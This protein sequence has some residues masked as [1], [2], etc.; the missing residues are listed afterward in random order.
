VALAC[1]EYARAV[2]V[3]LLRSAVALALA[4]G[5]VAAVVQP[6][7]ADQDV[8][9]SPTPD[10]KHP[11]ILDGRVYGIASRGPKVLV[12]GTFTTIRNGAFGTRQIRQPRLFRFDSDTGLIDKT[13]RPRINGDVE[14]VTYADGGTSILV[15]GSFTRVNGKVANRIAKLHL[16]GTL[17]RSFKASAARRVKDFALT[18]GRLILGGEFNKINGRDVQRLAAINPRTGAL[19]RTFR[20][21]AT[22]SRD[23]FAP[24]V[25]DLDV[26]PDGRWLVIGGNFTRV[27]G[28]ERHQVA[29]INLGGDRPRVSQWST[30]RYRGDC[31]VSYKDTYIRGIDISPDSRFF[32][33][34]TTGAFIG[35]DLMC[36]SSCPRSSSPNTS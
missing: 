24:Y 26:S 31:A 16:N 4:L 36:D 32:V 34:N 35:F 12:A 17:D 22:G 33:V 2:R 28:K 13:F 30:G 20:I 6:A 7:P 23:R 5:L 3:G 21:Q 18:G 8:V 29:V 9:V 10:P 11:R 19:D 1:G 27:G 15:A 14:A 25:Q